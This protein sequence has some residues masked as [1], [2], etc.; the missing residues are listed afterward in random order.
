MS[1][2]DPLV[3]IPDISK[4]ATVLIE[5]ISDAVGGIFEP[6]QIRRIADA[7]ATALKIRATAQIEVTELQRRAFS[8][9]LL[10]EG[11]K[12][13]NIEAIAA[14]AIPQ[15][16]DDA[17]PEKIE[18]DWITNFFDKCR[19]VSD[20][21][22]QHLWAR[23]LSGEANSPGRFSKRTLNLLAALDKT[24]AE[25]FTRLCSFAWVMGA[26]TALVYDV[27]ATIYTNAGINFNGLTHL[28]EI[29]LLTFDNLAGFRRLRLPQ[30]N[31]FFYYGQP[32]VVTFSL[33]E[34]N[35]IDIGRVLLS[36]SGIEFAQICGGQPI[37]GFRD[38]VLAKWRENGY[39]I[40]E[41]STSVA[42]SPQS[43]LEPS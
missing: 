22:M 16:A 42:S 21:E 20:D 4:P 6:W 17:Q 33:P 28:Q 32:V 30:K 39:Q 25:L 31:T 23:I 2:R 5:R 10:E 34:N 35:E 29:G 14:K 37:P 18:T 3:N 12:Q 43:V 7:E 8:R 11:H 1:E 40:E 41:S 13:E 19:L 15:V 27:D 36:W 9:F 26:V 24:D 38:F